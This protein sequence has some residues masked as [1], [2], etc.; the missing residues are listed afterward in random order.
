MQILNCWRWSQSKRRSAGVF[1]HFQKK[2]LTPSRPRHASLSGTVSSEQVPHMGQTCYSGPEMCKPGSSKTY[3]VP[4]PRTGLSQAVFCTTAA[5]N[6]FL[7]SATFP[8]ERVGL[9]PMTRD[10][11]SQL[12]ESDAASGTATWFRI[13]SVWCLPFKL[14]CPQGQKTAVLESNVAEDQIQKQ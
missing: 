8:R 7:I 3:T 11:C 9:W 4:L 14:H 13:I 5:A 12:I 10:R 6:A 2:V 1:I